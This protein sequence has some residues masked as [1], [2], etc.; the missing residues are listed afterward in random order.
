[1]S[2]ATG[3]FVP[4]YPWSFS[5]GN[6]GVNWGNLD[7]GQGVLSPILTRNLFVQSPFGIAPTGLG[8]ITIRYASFT[9]G[10]SN[11][12]VVA[13]LLQGAPTTSAGRSGTATQVVVPI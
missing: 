6:Y 9:D 7:F 12:H 4:A 5:K 11:T 1:M 10:T 3:G 2:K 13:E 8:P